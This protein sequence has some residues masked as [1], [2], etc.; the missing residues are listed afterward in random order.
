MPTSRLP[1]LNTWIIESQRDLEIQDFFSPSVLDGDWRSV[2]EQV[3]PLLDGYTGRLGIHG[4]DPGP[5]TLASWDPAVSAVMTDRLKRSMEACAVMGAT[6]MVVHSPF[7][8]LGTH[9]L[10][11]TPTM[12][13]E[14]YF[15]R[16]RD[17]LAEVLPLAEAA[18]CTIVIENIWDPHP[19]LLVGLVQSLASPWVRMSIDIG[20]AYLAHGRGAM[21]PDMWVQHAGDLLGHVHL[22]DTDFYADRHW[23][24][25]QGQVRWAP[26][27]EALGQLSQQPRL[28]LEVKGDPRDGLRWLAEQSLAR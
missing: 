1:E 13:H 24:P 11:N 27:F 23:L 4:P 3:R 21:P 6:H 16:T 2:A 17:T 9:Y 14:S 18:G 5:G 8:F 26:V 15:E 22:Q 28:I 25:G 20:H 7:I 10:P 12:G 19:G